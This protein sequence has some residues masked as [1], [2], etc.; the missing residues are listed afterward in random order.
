MIYNSWKFQISLHSL[1]TSSSPLSILEDVDSTFSLH[2][3]WFI[4][5]LT[6]ANELRTEIKELM[7]AHLMLS[8]CLSR[9]PCTHKWGFWKWSDYRCCSWLAVSRWV[10][11]EEAGQCRCDLTE[12]R[13][14]LAPQFSLLAG[15]HDMNSFPSLCPSAVLSCLGARGLWIENMSQISLCFKLWVSDIVSQC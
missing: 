1:N 4:L 7:W 6:L 13:S 10:W 3:L 5:W 12:Y 9:A 11:S 2:S 8:R 14:L 15:C